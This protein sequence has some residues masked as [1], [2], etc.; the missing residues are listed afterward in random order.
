MTTFNSAAATA[1]KATATGATS[2]G[3]VSIP[4]LAIGDLLL[5]VDPPG[6]AQGFEEVVS[7]ANQIQQTANLD[8]STVDFTFYL[9]RGV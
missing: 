2:A 5:V 8:W 3:V 7:V 1:I 6:F 4:G 9:L